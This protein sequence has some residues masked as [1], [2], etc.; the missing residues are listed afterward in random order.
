MT[1]RR[2]WLRHTTLGVMRGLDPRIHL[3]SQDSSQRW[4]A[5]S[6]P[7]MTKSRRGLFARLVDRDVLAVCDRSAA[8]SDDQRI[9]FDEAMA[10]LLV[11]AGHFCARGQFIAATRR[12]EKLHPAADMNP[13]AEDGVVDQHLVHDAL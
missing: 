1:P 10:F 9:E 13:R 5:G 4:I 11:I 12:C 2:R 6:S 3:S 8:V 7:A